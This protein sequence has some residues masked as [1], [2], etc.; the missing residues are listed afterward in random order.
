VSPPTADPNSPPSAD[1]TYYPQDPEAGETVHF[2]DESSDQTVIQSRA[3]E[4]GDGDTST[5]EN[6]EHTYAGDGTYNVTLTVTDATG[7][8][9]SI[10]KPVAVDN[11]HPI[12]S[13]T[14]EPSEPEET[15]TVTFTADPQDP[16]EDYGPVQWEFPNHTDTGET[17]N[18]TFQAE[19]SYNVTAS[20][21]D[22]HGAT[23]WA[24][25][26]VEV[27]NAPPVPEFRVD[28]PE[29]IALE[30]VTLISESEDPGEGEIVN[31]TWEIDGSTVGFGEKTT[32][33]FPKDGSVPV[34]LTLEDDD[35]AQAELEREIDVANAAPELG[36]DIS[37]TPPI[38]EKTTEFE[39]KVE[40]DDAQ[41]TIEWRFEDGT[42]LEGET[43]SRVFDE[44]GTSEVELF[45]EDADGASSS[46][47]RSFEIDHLPTV[48]VS[49]K[50]SDESTQTN[51]LTDEHLTLE[52]NAEDPDGDAVTIDWLV[53]GRE[54]ETTLNCE[55][56]PG[57][58]A[59]QIECDWPDDGT[60]TLAARVEDE[61]GGVQTN[62]I[63]VEVDNRVPSV[64]PDVAESV[65][66][67][68]QTVELVAH[69]QDPDGEVVDIVWDRS[70]T[71]IGKGERLQYTFQKAGKQIVWLNATDDDDATRSG[72]LVVHVNEPPRVDL[73]FT[74]NKPNAGES[75][76][77]TATASDPDGD[78]SNLDHEWFFES[79]GTATGTTVTEDF[80]DGGTF[81]VNVT[82]FD[83]DGGTATASDRIDVKVPPLEATLS[84]Q[85]NVPRVD[86][87]VSFDIDVN[88]VRDIEKVEWS[89]GDGETATTSS[90][91]VTHT[92]M[93]SESFQVDA[94]VH[95]DHG[96]E[97]TLSTT[98]RVT[99]D[100]AASFRV[101]PLLPDGQCVDI[102]SDAFG[103]EATNLGNGD[104]ISLD[105]TER[106]WERLDECTVEWTLNP[107]TWAIGDRL[108]VE[109]TLGI[110]E[111][112]RTYILDGP[113]EPG[114]VT[115]QFSKAPLSFATFDV[116]PREEDALLGAN[117]ESNH[118][119][120]DPQE[121][122]HVRGQ[123]VWADG[124]PVI[125]ASVGL[126]AEYLGPLALLPN[127]EY[128]SWT[129]STN[130]TG[131]FTTRVPA[132]VLEAANSERFNIQGQPVLYPPGDYG[133]T[134]SSGS[135]TLG[136]T[137]REAFR[138]DPFGTFEVLENNG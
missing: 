33:E 83:E 26:T 81:R 119:F 98:V 132:V 23:A 127:T 67:A 121:P 91:S 7:Q 124:T 104:R 138:E 9:D 6:P 20:V 74:P 115:L 66:N 101:Q 22:E 106:T 110:A 89:F 8:S 71:L 122:V 116:L 137:A 112:D 69:A 4:F 60:H 25:R 13:F 78:D 59:N 135:N 95:A 65:V 86:D 80:E 123:V 105:G 21:T 77:F 68:G 76:E 103:L 45:A 30:P 107:G 5:S 88:D 118:T 61:H 39:A 87:T 114:L 54:P 64:N 111:L 12:L 1:F 55:V 131:G 48:S 58:D 62:A 37:P 24:N 41:E 126:A 100:D 40:D 102:D 27:A 72:K 31:H 93:A 50:G 96:T 79:E 108:R 125:D 38:P 47:N 17:V 75:V 90:G 136:D 52:A 29:P 15:Q 2:E 134:A 10:T 128:R 73:D 53:D 16:E 85:P 49:P 113:Y 19:A 18:A 57:P 35:G 94:T 14:Y 82:V 42:T 36:M 120:H 32:A 109:A 92:Y 129:V 63:V 11:A 51:I 133:V 70:G 46:I 97:D 117:D 130:V 44:G 56:L 99:R 3:W 28:P 43:V 84:T 34:T